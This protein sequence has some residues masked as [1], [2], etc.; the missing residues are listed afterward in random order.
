VTR[1]GGGSTAIAST[2]DAHGGNV[3]GGSEHDDCEHGGDAHGGN[4]HDDREHNGHAHG[5]NEHDDRDHDSGA[6]G[7]IEHDD[8]DR[9]RRGRTSTKG[10]DLRLGYRIPPLPSIGTHLAAPRIVTRTYRNIPSGTPLQSC[11]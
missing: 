4:K 9:G 1:V 3:H 7:G 11:C 6:H 5:G 2:G 10:A 8:G